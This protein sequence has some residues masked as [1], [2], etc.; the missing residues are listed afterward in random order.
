[1][2]VC[3]E[4]LAVRALEQLDPDLYVLH[5]EYPSRYPSSSKGILENSSRVSQVQHFMAL[6]TFLGDNNHYNT[7]LLFPHTVAFIASIKQELVR[8]KLAV[9]TF[10]KCNLDLH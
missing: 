7:P 9:F 4:K 1:M 8:A 3:V 6:R 5:T 2:C 10:L